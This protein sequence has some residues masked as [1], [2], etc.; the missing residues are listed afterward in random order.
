MNAQNPQPIENRGRLA[1]VLLSLLGFVGVA[2]GGLWFHIAV[3]P[4]PIETSAGLVFRFLYFVLWLGGLIYLLGR[5]FIGPASQL[6]QGLVFLVLGIFVGYLGGY[7]FAGPLGLVVGALTGA[8]LG[9]LVFFIRRRGPSGA[10][11]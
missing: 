3:L 6:W 2:V 4:L 9:P 7:C 11:P 8:L 1:S 10:K 5:A